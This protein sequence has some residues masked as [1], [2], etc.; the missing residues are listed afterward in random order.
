MRPNVKIILGTKFHK[1]LN[2]LY[3]NIGDSACKTQPPAWHLDHMVHASV[4][5][6]DA[7]IW[8]VSVLPVV[9]SKP[10]VDSLDHTSG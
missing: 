4:K 8:T 5:I 9:T 6:P 2:F 1:K 7:F 3:R 10:A